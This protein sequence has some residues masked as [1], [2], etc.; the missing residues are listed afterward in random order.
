MEISGIIIKVLPQKNGTSQ[1]GE[2]SS[3]QY[4]LETNE[5]YPKKFLFEVF[6]AE[7]IKNFAITEGKEVTVSFDTDAREHNGIWYASNRAWKVVL[8]DN[9]P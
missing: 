2:W 4:V 5:Q 1:K 3:Q 7:R 8:K 9:I 6:G